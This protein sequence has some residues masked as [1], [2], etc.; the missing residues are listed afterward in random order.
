MEREDW[1][2]NNSENHQFIVNMVR[3]QPSN[4][5]LI[6]NNFQREAKQ[7]FNNPR[8]LWLAPTAY[9]GARTALFY[10]LKYRA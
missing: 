8:K 2:L 6:A 5:E 1:E 9:K 4:V 7:C 3:Q 10:L